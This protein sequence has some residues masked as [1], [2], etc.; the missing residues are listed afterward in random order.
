MIDF[1]SFKKGAQILADRLRLGWDEAGCYDTARLMAFFIP[2]IPYMPEELRLVCNGVT[3]NMLACQERRDW[4]GLADYLDVEVIE[5]LDAVEALMGEQLEGAS[6]V[7]GN[8][9]FQ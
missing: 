2:I 6:G 8:E 5:L 9:V 7:N 1:E 4:L 3:A